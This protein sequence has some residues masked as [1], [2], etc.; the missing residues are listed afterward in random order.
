M[1]GLCSKAIAFLISKA[2][3][4][5]LCKRASLLH[6]IDHDADKQSSVN[7]ALANFQKHEHTKPGMQ[8]VPCL[9]SNEVLRK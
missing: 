3:R 8:A 6:L 4:T 7:S 2:K 1:A 9:H 5:R